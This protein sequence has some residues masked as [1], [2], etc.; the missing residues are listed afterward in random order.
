VHDIIFNIYNF[1]TSINFFNYTEFIQIIHMIKKMAEHFF[2]Y[3]K[4]SF[5]SYLLTDI[6][7]TSFR[8]F[9]VKKN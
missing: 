8:R 2:R 7:Y 1:F 6:H 5:F 4:K 9:F 3:L